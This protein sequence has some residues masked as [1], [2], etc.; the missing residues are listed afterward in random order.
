MTRFG[1]RCTVLLIGFLVC[2]WCSADEPIALNEDPALQDY[3]YAKNVGIPLDNR[4]KVFVP[5]DKKANFT[6]FQGV[7]EVSINEQGISFTLT[8]KEATL[9]WGNYMGEQPI[10]EMVDTCQ[11]TMMVHL[12]V[13]QTQ[14]DSQWV[15]HFW[16]DGKR[17]SQTAKAE[18]KGVA[19]QELQF[20]KLNLEGPRPDGLEFTIKGEQG[21]RLTLEWL[22]IIQPTYEGY[23]RQEFTLPEGKIWRAVANVGSMNYRN[24]YG[25]REM[26]SRL[27]LNG[28]AVK[29]RGALDIYHTDAVDIAP[30]LQPGKNCVG[31][32]GFRIEYNPFLYVQAK[33]IMESGEIVTIAS[34]DDW[35]YSA[36]EEEGWSQPGFDDSK[37]SAPV[38][39]VGGINPQ[40]RDFSG[41]VG[42][43]AYS[44]CLLIENP[45]RAQLFYNDNDEIKVNVRVPRGLQAQQPV[46]F[47]A[48][49]KSDAGGYCNQVSD[50]KSE[51]YAETDGS[52][53][54]SFNLGKQ[55]NGIYALA[56]SLADKD[57]KIIEKRHREPMVVLRQ[58]ALKAIQGNNFTDG[59]DYELE[60]TVEFTQAEPAKGNSR[61]VE[62]DGLKYREVDSKNRG[63]GYTYTFNFQHPGDFYFM[64]LEYPDNAKR[65]IEAIIRQGRSTQTGPG[66]ETGGRFLTTGKMQTLKW[67]H[68]A[69]DGEHT[70]NIVNAKDNE[71]AAATAMKIYHIKGDL[72]ELNYGTSRSYGIHTE[73]CGGGSGIMHNFGASMPRETVKDGEQTLMRSVLSSL[74]SMAEIGERYVQYLKF[75][76][77]NVHIMGCYQ[78]MEYNTPFVAMPIVKDSRVL[79]CMKTMMANLFENNGIDFYA[80]LEFS[81][82]RGLK[83]YANNAMVANGADSLYFIDDKG[84]Q[85]YG[86]ATVST[87]QNW[88]HPLSVQQYDDLVEALADTYGHLSHF[89]GIHGLLGANFG[90]FG[91]WMPGFGQGSNY[92][93]PLLLSFDDITVGLFEEDTGIKLPIERT[94]TER[95]AKRAVLLRSPDY[96]QK[97]LDWRADK[98]TQFFAREVEIL[99]KKRP[100][101]TFINALT[102]GDTAIY[103][104]LSNS[105]QTFGELMKDFAIDIAGMNAIDG[106]TTG[107]WTV[108]WQQKTVGRLMVSQDPFLWMARV[109]PRVTSAFDS[110]SEKCVLVR[111]SWDE[112]TLEGVRVSA[113]PQPSGYFAREA[114]MQAIITG[115]PNIL[116]GGWTDLHINVGSEQ[117]IREITKPF[118]HLPKEKFEPVL[119]TGLKTSVAIRKL[120]KGNESWFYIANPGFWHIKGKVT[121]E[122]QSGTIHNIATN[123]QVPIDINRPIKPGAPV[124]YDIKFDLPPFGMVALKQAL[125]PEAVAD[126]KILSY[127]VEP[128]APEEL[129]RLTRVIDRAEKLLDDDLTSKSLSTLDQE[130][131]RQSI[132]QARE[133]IAARNYGLAWSLVTDTR[134]WLQWQDFLEQAVDA[135]AVLPDSVRTEPQGDD[136]NQLPSISARRTDTPITIDGNPD[137]A[138]WQQAPFTT[139]FW[140]GTVKGKKSMVETGIKLLYDDNTLYMAFA[141]A[142]RNP[143]E[144]KATAEGESQIFSARDDILA[145]FIQPD[146]TKPLYYQMVFNAKGANFD[147]RVKGGN[148]D[149]EFDPEWPTAV[150]KHDG[151]WT[152]EVALPYAAFDLEGPQKEWRAN[153]LRRVRDNMAAAS[154]WS[155]MP[156]TAWHQPERFGYLRFE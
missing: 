3:F 104:K 31:F 154:G 145:F 124:D 2:S 51:T 127:E 10:E 112:N 98:L 140:M 156:G 29:R 76:G 37:W 103:E 116:F 48:F 78:Y 115:D 73:R 44:G 151:Y 87:L 65:V 67:I 113:L 62:Q 4:V 80:G 19:S 129:S 86:F 131:M 16:R 28:K 24:W 45:D 152:A 90:M 117:I 69:D 64:E 108:S 9:G 125:A 155:F 106:L 95:F 148:P 61:L 97:F 72:P 71:P 70:I 50:G 123:E 40:K 105:N 68:V 32:Y 75:T 111:S 134:F 142:D 46:L 7:E 101:L 144:L 59:L 47:Y 139:G 57:G 133:A 102:A 14:G 109:D 56:L 146:E 77:Q 20:N 85:R 128:I 35:K 36:K 66:V 13:S 122:L 33:I 84:Q 126:L 110:G 30:Y 5:S 58:K 41:R 54:Y 55:E 63:I 88:L 23:C 96:R 27:Y 114:F 135:L 94:D 17:E 43:P 143:E 82:Y 130:Y 26:I 120:D 147:Q 119:D 141:C 83:T 153:F 99:K 132:T 79:Q 91:Y 92:D 42:I 93:D 81:Q 22:K 38:A 136:V 149:Y 1:Q 6:A 74:Y 100:D 21:S 39:G 107:R 121:I 18:A 150:S 60:S 52:L 25:T 49:G 118:T 8:D 34:G 53:V 89:K 138:A 11:D 15:M 137:E 12:K